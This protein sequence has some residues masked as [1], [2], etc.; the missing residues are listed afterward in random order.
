MV[1]EYNKKRKDQKN[2]NNNKRKENKQKNYI[3]N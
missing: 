3:V 1:A 2:Y